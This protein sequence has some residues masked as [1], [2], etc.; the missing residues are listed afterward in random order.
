MTYRE[1]RKLKVRVSY[2]ENRPRRIDF[3]PDIMV[4]KLDRIERI[5][6]YLRAF[7]QTLTYD[8]F[9]NSSKYPQQLLIT[10]R[11]IKQDYY[12]KSDLIINNDL[13]VNICETNKNGSWNSD[14]EDIY[15]YIGVYSTAC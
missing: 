4:H 8:N 1:Y 2:S 7:D 13:L 9:A 15:I 3:G 5:F 12:K 10:I 6:V 14:D 11:N